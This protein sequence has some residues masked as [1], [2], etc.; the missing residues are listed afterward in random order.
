MS[1]G[2]AAAAQPQTLSRQVT[3]AMLWNAVLQPARLV[4]G[5]LSGIVLGNVLPR[6][7]YGAYALLGAMAASLGLVVDFGVERSLVKFLPE[8]EARYGREGVRRTLWLVVAQKMAVLAIVIALALAFSGRFFA[9]WHS[10]L[11]GAD[12][13]L[14]RGI[15]DE[16]RWLFF[17]A[18]MGL[19]VFGALFDVYMQVLVSY[20]HQRAWNGI[21]LVYTLLR[22]LLFIAVVLAGWGILGVVGAMVAVPALATALAFWQALTV[23]RTLADRPTLPASGARILPRFVNYSI[24]SYFIQLSEYAYS[25]NFVVLALPGAGVAGGFKIANSL[26]TDVLSALWSPMVGVQIPLFAR[27]HARGDDRQLAAAYAI[28]SKFLAALLIPAAVGLTVLAGNILAT[29]W[30]KYAAYAGVARILA[31]ALCFD[32]ALSVPLSVLMAYERYRPMAIARVLGLVAIPLVLVLVPR[33]GAVAAALI[34]GGARLASDGLAM[35]LAMRV[36][37]LRYPLAFAARIAAASLGMALVVAPI[38]LLALHPRAGLPVGPRAAYLA[39]NLALGGLGAGVYLLLF[40][41][42]GGLDPTDRRRIA[43]LRLPAASFLLRFF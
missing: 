1:D 17:G 22:P 31:L 23:R 28:L 18:L 25:F 40:R 3:G 11:G 6:P 8:I 13:R 12:E 34:M 15:L 29:V 5:L 24:L 36:L 41:L 35:A 7:E 27:L 37:P 9:F 33:Y 32:A 10:R 42:T 38:A 26:V 16:H 2:E 19:I 4:A 21:N 14:M 20:F 43:E 39:A 30:P